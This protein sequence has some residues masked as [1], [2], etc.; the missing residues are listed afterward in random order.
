MKKFQN[1]ISN[2]SFKSQSLNYL[3]FKY[4]F[5]IWILSFV[6]L[7]STA[8]VMGE[9]SRKSVD[10]RIIP[11]AS[12]FTLKDLKGN[13][14]TLS[15]FKGKK[16]LLTFGA[17]WCPYC[18]QEVADLKAF[19]DKHQDKDI[20]LI[21]VDIRETA[22]KV[23]AFIKKHDIKYTVVLD[24]DGEIARKYEVY[25]IPAVFLIDESGI[26]KYSGSGKPE[27]GFEGLL[28]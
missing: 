19:F 4:S 15:S 12:D 14:V 5:V 13:S 20:K 23:A 26:V 11:Y 27:G 9:T 25:G 8:N 28:K 24:S 10:Q 18:V 1:Q 3:L 17:T 2:Q 7:S 16:V 22:D 6:I 21:S